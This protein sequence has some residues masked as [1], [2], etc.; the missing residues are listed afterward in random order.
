MFI[1]NSLKHTIIVSHLATYIPQVW[2]L[3]L[4]MVVLFK[5]LPLESTDGERLGKMRHCQNHAL[6]IQPAH[7][8]IN[9]REVDFYLANLLECRG[10][11]TGESETEEDDSLNAFGVFRMTDIDRNFKA[12]LMFSLGTQTDPVSIE[13]SPNK[14]QRFDREDEELRG[15][16]PNSRRTSPNILNMN[17]SNI[18]N[19]TPV[20]IYPVNGNIAPSAPSSPRSLNNIEF[21]TLSETPTTQSLRPIG[22]RLVTPSPYGN[23]FTLMPGQYAVQSREPSNTSRLGSEIFHAITTTSD[24]APSSTQQEIKYIQSLPVTSNPGPVNFVGSREFGEEVAKPEITKNLITSSSPVYT[25]TKSQNS[26]IA[27]RSKAEFHV[28]GSSSFKPLASQSD[29]TRSLRSS[30]FN[31]LQSMSGN[32]RPSSASTTPRGTPTTLN[33]T[34]WNAPRDGEEHDIH[35]QHIQDDISVDRLFNL[36]NNTTP[37]ITPIATPIPTR[38][39]SRI[40]SPTTSGSAFTPTTNTLKSKPS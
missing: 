5:A 13:P 10:R 22:S 18:K 3:D 4:V 23:T 16:N 30:P 38:P 39:Q 15:I 1:Y 12:P 40:H 20:M 33:L 24:A 28:S 21:N 32:S 17:K 25:A 29:L 11:K 2:R 6:C 8:T 34:Y 14:K 27:T 7:I 9:I 37:G 31:L 26:V 19:P 35:M 36:V